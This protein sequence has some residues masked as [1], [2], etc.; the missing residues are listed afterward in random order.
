MNYCH[1]GKVVCVETRR[2]ELGEGV[3]RV[4]EA[5][6]EDG[7]LVTVG[8]SGFRKEGDMMIPVRERIPVKRGDIIPVIDRG[9]DTSVTVRRIKAG[10]EL[11]GELPVPVRARTIG[12]LNRKLARLSRI[13]NETE[14]YHLEVERDGVPNAG[15]CPRG[16]DKV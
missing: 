10:L 5:V 13:G 1:V 6:L 2:A 11:V 16:W 3:G 7:E 15:G 8:F 4:T 9:V 14:R 12:R